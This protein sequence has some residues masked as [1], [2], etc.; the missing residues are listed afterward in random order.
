MEHD[1]ILDEIYE[2]VPVELSPSYYDPLN[3]NPA[4]LYLNINGVCWRIKAERHP[5]D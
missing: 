2:A 4:E 1:E 3:G 5:H